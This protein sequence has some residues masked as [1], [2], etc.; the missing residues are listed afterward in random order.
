MRGIV[1][2]IKAIGKEIRQSEAKVENKMNK[3]LTKEA[4]TAIIISWIK[5]SADKEKIKS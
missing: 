1:A 5:V 3:K 2:A 4:I